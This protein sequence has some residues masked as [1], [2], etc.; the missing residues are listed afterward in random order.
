MVRIKKNTW[1]P[2]YPIDTKEGTC[3]LYGDKGLRKVSNEKWDYA[4]KGPYA[5]D[6]SPV[7]FPKVIKDFLTGKIKV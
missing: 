2:N 7:D 5:N 6:F 4:T 3:Y 1:N